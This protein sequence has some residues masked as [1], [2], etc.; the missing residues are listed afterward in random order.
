VPYQVAFF[1]NPHRPYKT[2][3]VDTSGEVVGEIETNLLAFLAGFAVVHEVAR[4][5]TYTFAYRYID[6]YSARWPLGLHAQFG[7]HK[8]EQEPPDDGRPLNRSDDP[9]STDGE[10]T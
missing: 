6:T 4:K 2:V 9:F 8:A 1:V 10:L 5:D 3:W 7:K